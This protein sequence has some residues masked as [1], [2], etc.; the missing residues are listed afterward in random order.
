MPPAF[1]SE[2]EMG[3]P[4]AAWLRDRGFDVYQEV[5]PHQGGARADLVGLAERKPR[6]VAVVELKK[7]FSIDVLHQA[8]SWRE[9]AH[10]VYV[11]VPAITGRGGGWSLRRFCHRVAAD[12]G[13]GVL[14]LKPP[15]RWARD[16]ALEER[17]P[18]QLRRRVDDTLSSFLRPEHKTFAAAGTN[19]GGYWTPFRDTATR[20]AAIVI[21]HGAP[22]IPLKQALKE[23][24]KHHYANDASARACLSTLARQGVIDGIET[25]Y[26]G[27]QLLLRPKTSK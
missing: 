20:L 2:Q 17:V 22:G 16:A 9:H 18:A 4:V 14:E 13:I 3:P 23:L 8:H 25:A 26:V 19:G 27:K 7:S 6:I 5:R 21:N 15:D 12:Y 1:A 24:G 10:L 11:A